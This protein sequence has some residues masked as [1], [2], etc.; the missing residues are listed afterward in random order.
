MAATIHTFV[1]RDKP[2]RDA[3]PVAALFRDHGPEA[4]RILRRKLSFLALEVT[5]ASDLIKVRN[6]A[7]IPQRLWKIGRI[8]RD[9]GL[10][11][12]ADSA[13]NAS[14]ATRDPAFA[15][16]WSRVLRLTEAALDPAHDLRVGSH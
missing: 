6:L 7:D 8:A 1:P 11:S 3:A 13:L 2:R 15:A 12:L 4:H 10:I 16:I 9:L 5:G 14:L